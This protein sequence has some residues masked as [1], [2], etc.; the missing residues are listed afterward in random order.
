MYAI[1]HVALSVAD[2]EVSKAFYEKL[3]FKEVHFWQADDESLTITHLKNGDFILELFCYKN[4]TPAP[5]TI[6]AT[7]TDLPII[8]T[9]HFGLQVASIEAAREDLAAKDIVKP[10][11]EITQGRTGPRYFF[12]EDPDGILVEIAEDGRKFT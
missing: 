12:I 8:G 4:Y 11:I 9:K 10:D 5:E 6:H 3:D 1:H 7:A 2:R